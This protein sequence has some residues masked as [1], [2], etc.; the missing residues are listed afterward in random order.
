MHAKLEAFLD[1]A[2]QTFQ[3]Y[4]EADQS[5][6]AKYA[7]AIAY[8]RETETARALKAIDALILEHPDDPYLE[9]LKGQ[10]LFEVGRAKEAEVPH[11]R[12]VELKPDAPLLRIN[13]GQALIAQNDPAK[14]DEAI[15]QVNKALLQEPDNAL[16]WRLLS[17]AYDAKNQPGMARL[18]A[19]E[20]NFY[21]GQLL[22]AR[23]FAL[24]ARK[25]LIKGVQNGGAPPTS[26][27]PQNPMPRT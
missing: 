9:E 3:D 19:A 24:N 23:T 15:A 5:F 17:E 21:L 10:V 1:G 25:S 2:G 22:I 4:P 6:P 7:R 18:A 13:L 8:Y 14:L 20:Q 27:W 26:S 12:S 11:R 16:G